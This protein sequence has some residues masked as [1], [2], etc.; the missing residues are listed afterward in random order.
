MIICGYPG[1]GKT[2]LAGAKVSNVEDLK[3]IDLDSSSFSGGSGI[4]TYIRV[5]KSLSRQ[6]C[7]VFVSTHEDLVK[8]L[9]T[10]RDVPVIV[11]YPSPELRSEWIKKLRD[12]YTNCDDLDAAKNLRAFERAR[13]HYEEDI[14]FLQNCG[15]PGMQIEDMDYDLITELC[16]YM[17]GGFKQC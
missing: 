5:A 3:F 8:D 9:S 1:I 4:S 16:D 13:D 17:F 15:L 6:G 11:C 7:V 2:S 12:R 10:V 14:D